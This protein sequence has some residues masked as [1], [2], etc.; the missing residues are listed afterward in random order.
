MY[1]LQWFIFYFHQIPLAELSG[2]I[3]ILKY[4]SFST[5]FKP[6][7]ALALYRHFSAGVIQLLQLPTYHNS[8]SFMHHGWRRIQTCGV[9]P[10]V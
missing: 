3:C 1:S 7:T 10:Y 9:F 6:R 2:L 8:Y 5:L 4:V